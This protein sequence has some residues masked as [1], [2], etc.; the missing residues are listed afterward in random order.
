MTVVLVQIVLLLVLL[1][2]LAYLVA[3][4]LEFVRIHKG[5]VPFVPSTTAI[6]RRTLERREGLLDDDQVNGRSPPPVFTTDGKRPLRSETVSEVV[7]DIC[8][9]MLKAGEARAPFQM[10][11]LRRTAET[12]LASLGISRDVRGQIQSHG[13]GG[14]QARH[15]DRHD[16]ALE[17]RAALEKWQ[18]YLDKLRRG[19]TAQV[20]HPQFG[21][22]RK[23]R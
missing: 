4:F 2:L 18:R 14:V 13:L 20:A 3:L 15:Y 16:Y 5:D 23:A 7:R 22:K 10:R 19:D 1:V 6:L 8:E 21:A 17:K 9:A 11:D 12:M